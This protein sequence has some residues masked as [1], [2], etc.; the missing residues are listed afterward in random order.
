MEPGDTEVAPVIARQY[1]S[2]Q[3]LQV[4]KTSDDNLVGFGIPDGGNINQP[5]LIVKLSSTDGSLIWRKELQETDLDGI[6]SIARSPSGGFVVS[7]R[8]GPSALLMA[9]DDNGNSLWRK[10][11]RVGTGTVALVTLTADNDLAV[12]TTATKQTPPYGGGVGVLKV[13]SN[14][15]SIS[16]YIN[17]GTPMPGNAKIFPMRDNSV[18][19]TGTVGTLSL[20]DGL[21]KRIGADGK[22]TDS[23]QLHVDG[24]GFI[25]TCVAERPG[26]GIICCGIEG[27]AQSTTGSG[28]AFAMRISSN[29]ELVDKRTVHPD[30]LRFILTDI[31]PTDE[32]F[33]AVGSGLTSFHVSEYPIAVQMD[34]TMSIKWHKTYNAPGQ[35]YHQLVSADLVNGRTVVTGNSWRE[36]SFDTYTEQEFFVMDMSRSGKARE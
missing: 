29:M 12:V 18:V 35:K 28:V 23:L 11:Y 7:S 16:L 19:L 24:K 2:G 32:G 8:T 13:N 27:L 22:I 33:L 21:F 10:T 17:L 3:L 5:R 20:G 14:G 1:N 26:G 9:F 4:I 25:P 31:I 15:D 6:Q 34:N 30:S 36:S